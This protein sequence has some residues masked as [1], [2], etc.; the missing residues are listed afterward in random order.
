MRFN[1]DSCV[2]DGDYV[3]PDMLKKIRRI[4]KATSS[5]VETK[6]DKHGRAVRIF[7]RS[8]HAAEF[9]AALGDCLSHRIIW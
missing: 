1:L 3:M 9:R 4:A 6:A 5:R 7:T 8:R 2:V